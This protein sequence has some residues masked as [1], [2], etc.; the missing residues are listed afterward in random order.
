MKNYNCARKKV[1]DTDFSWM[2]PNWKKKVFFFSLLYDKQYVMDQSQSAGIGSKCFS[3][4]TNESTNA[5]LCSG[6]SPASHSLVSGSKKFN[7]E[8]FLLHKCSVDLFGLKTDHTCEIYPRRKIWNIS[9]FKVKVRKGIWEQQPGLFATV[10][11]QPGTGHFSTCSQ[12]PF[13]SLWSCKGKSFS[14]VIISIF[15]CLRATQAVRPHVYVREKV[16]NVC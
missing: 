5:H 7:K 14:T 16:P 2:K 13:F 10:K 9:H 12:E 15:D 11:V 1:A 8:H 4:E 3:S 6:L